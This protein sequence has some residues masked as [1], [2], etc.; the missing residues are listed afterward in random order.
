MGGSWKTD[1]LHSW[2]LSARRRERDL[3]EISS[4]ATHDH[5]RQISGWY[6]EGSSVRDAESIAHAR[7]D[8]PRLLEE[9]KRLHARRRA[10]AS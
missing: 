1:H 10:R 3:A 5:V 6:L 4:T 9:I 8:V 2:A 7:R